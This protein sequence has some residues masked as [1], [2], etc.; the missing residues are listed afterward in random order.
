MAVE[1][2]GIEFVT[3]G[4]A[5]I[6]SRLDTL[7][8][9]MDTLGEQAGKSS[10]L[11]QNTLAV[12]LGNVLAKAAEV[13]TTALISVGQAAIGAFSD[14]FKLATDF[15]SAMTTLSIAAKS[16][17][18]SFD[19]L[20]D[21]AIAVGGDASLVGVSASGAADA[22][23]ELFKAGLS[24]VEVFGDLQ[25]FMAGTTDLSGALRAAIDLAAATEL[26]M[27]QA[28]ELAAVALSTFGGELETEEERAQFIRVAMDNF[29]KSADASVASVTDLA[30][31]LRN[32][33]PTA[34][35]FGFSLEDTNNALAILSTRGI[36]GAEAGTA[37][38]S[39][40]TNLMRPTDAV[41]E[42]LKELNVSLFNQDGVMR[43]L[44]EIIGD[45]GNAMEGLTEEQKLNH[46]QTL[47]GTF[48][49]KAFSTLLEEGTEGWNEMAAATAEAT[50]IQEQAIAKSQTLAGRFE[51][52]QGVIETL[53]I[54]IGD[55]FIPVA[56][57]LL[58]WATELAETFG[59]VIVGVIE[60]VVENFTDLAKAMGIDF[61]WE[62]IMPPEVADVIYFIIGALDDL[63]AWWNKNGP[64]I[65]KIA[66]DLFDTIK[67]AATTIVKTTM[68][69]LIRIL[70]RFGKWFDD[71]EEE[72]VNVIRIIAGALGILAESVA[73][74]WQVI[75][76]IFEALVNVV[77]GAVEVI[78][79]IIEG[80]W[81]EAWD[82]AQRIVED[83]WS[84]IQ[85]SFLALADWVTSWFGTSWQGVVDQWSDSWDMAGKIVDLAWKNITGA[86]DDSGKDIGKTLGTIE[87]NTGN[88]LTEVSKGIDKFVANVGTN[89]KNFITNIQEQWQL[90][91]EKVELISKT[92]L[93]SIDMFLREIVSDLFEW[94]GIEQEE[95]VERWKVIFEKM[96]FITEEIW[97]RIVNF[98][99]DKITSM[100]D[101]I[102]FI[103]ENI[104]ENFSNVF[105]AIV[106]VVTEKSQQIF[107]AITNKI[108]EIG[109]WIITN[110]S[111]IKGYGES[112]INAIRQG[113][114][115]VA[116]KIGDGVKDAIQSINLTIGAVFDK[117]KS[118]GADVLDGISTGIKNH[119]DK[120]VSALGTVLDNVIGILLNTTSTVYQKSL[121]AG[122][123]IIDGILQGVQNNI[124]SL[125]DFITSQVE[126]IVDDIVNALTGGGDS[127][128]DTDLDTG[129]D[130]DDTPMAMQ[131]MQTL[132]LA[133]QQLATSMQN[134][135]ATP[136]TSS[137]ALESQPVI[138]VP[139]SA[140]TNNT[141]TTNNAFNLTTQSVLR[142]GALEM[143]FETMSLVSR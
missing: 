50:G 140:V 28:S 112:I 16:T 116:H 25:G 83:A 75:A 74:M 69:V 76:P 33:G 68:P 90:F 115:S 129:R 57:E 66:N 59:P 58:V 15:E 85:D 120:L 123:A 94:L 79:N 36:S 70:D 130:D 136:F 56:K 119:W 11:I 5:E 131:Q 67:D 97:K 78:L 42:S 101:D 23:T 95:F 124:A 104:K 7:D 142:P 82:V 27:V 13:A 122:K 105:D 39:M 134:T 38:K 60:D 30:E 111:T 91:W 18:L 51:A 72:I 45:F 96:Q 73:A 22:M 52:F 139:E 14:S 17:G 8:T 121:S 110:W 48:G 106:T 12:T 19:D 86:I 143:E 137:L 81:N 138:S 64:K 89:I 84:G 63:G 34:A 80:D 35:S 141:T 61:P 77:L 113:I 49:M 109:E 128:E 21:A 125:V 41:K 3:Q 100:R 114:D 46:I 127:D 132:S 43:S 26:D 4:F 133:V 20:S 108:T 10:N 102:V 126:N 2:L 65:E 53:Q 117:L 118:I 88:S 32:V 1:T 40:M 54:T 107:D 37:L 98:I 9:K 87:K 93:E 71:N 44:P 92:I 135:T 62:D 29:V 24:N 31:A 47:A 55:A 6:N 99:V 103:L